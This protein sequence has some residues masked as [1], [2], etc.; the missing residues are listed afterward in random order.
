MAARLLAAL[1]GLTLGVALARGMVSEPPTY[2]IDLSARGLAAEMIVLCRNS[3]RSSS[4]I[5]WIGR[6]TYVSTKPGNTWRVR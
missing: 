6:P 4:R 1:A 3:A 5:A 2:L